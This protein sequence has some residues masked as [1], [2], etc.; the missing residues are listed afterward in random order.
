MD[1]PLIITIRVVPTIDIVVIF[2]VFQCSIAEI[3]PF[4]SDALL[5]LRG[6]N[7]L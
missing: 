4:L 7:S 5:S 6:G 2:N 3:V 1:I